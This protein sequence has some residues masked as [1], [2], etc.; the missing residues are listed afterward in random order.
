MKRTDRSDR[1]QM[2]PSVEPLEARDL[3][4]AAAVSPW[5][6]ND[7]PTDRQITALQSSGSSGSSGG[8]ETTPPDRATRRFFAAFTGSYVVGKGRIEGQALRTYLNLSGT[9][10]MFLHG[11]AQVAVAA[12]TDPTQ[13]LAGSATLFDKNYA[14]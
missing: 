5:P 7:P 4:S 2:G 11:Q 3:P 10:N 6:Q 1:R 13:G 14:Q 9:S 8:S 12:P